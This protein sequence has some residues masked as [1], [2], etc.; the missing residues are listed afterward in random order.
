MRLITMAEAGAVGP[1]IDCRPTGASVVCSDNCDGPTSRFLR[2][3]RN[4]LAPSGTASSQ[5]AM[6]RRL[7]GSYGSSGRR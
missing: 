6:L 5:D 3:A 2:A 4:K 1:E 7:P